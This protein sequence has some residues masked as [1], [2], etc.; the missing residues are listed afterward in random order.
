MDLN[1][2][3]RYH[4]RGGRSLDGFLGS[5]DEEA[6]ASPQLENVL[7]SNLT[8]LSLSGL[9]MLRDAEGRFTGA[10]RDSALEAVEI[11]AEPVEQAAVNDYH[12]KQGAL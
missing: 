12:N 3:A 6:V 7:R 10:V 2:Y 4:L 11:H 5:G 9:L 1:Y 8:T